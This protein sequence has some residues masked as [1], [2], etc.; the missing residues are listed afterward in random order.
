MGAFEILYFL[1]AIVV[2]GIT[3][4]L[5]TP[6]ADQFISVYDAQEITDTDSNNLVSALY[7][8]FKYGVP[9]IIAFGMYIW[10]VNVS[11]KQGGYI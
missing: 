4:I 7:Y 5:I 8:F 6:I 2:G 10:L 3:L 1:I 9:I 11:Q